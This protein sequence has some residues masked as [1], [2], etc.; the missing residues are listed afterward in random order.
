[1]SFAKAAYDAAE[2][3][4]VTV[5]VTLSA[6]PE[7]RVEIPITA[8]GGGG[9]EAGD[10][11]VAPASV[12][13][14][15]GDASKTF[16]LTATQDDVDDDGETVLL[17]FGA[18]PE[19][20]S[21]G[22]I[23]A[24]EV[25][26]VDDDTAAV[27]VSVSSLS[28]AEG[29]EGTYTVALGSEPTAAVTVTAA[30]A[31]G[32]GVT[33][34]PAALTFTASDWDS[35]QTVT[36]AAGHDD[37]AVD[38]AATV[39]HTAAG[40]GYDAVSASVEVTVADDENPAVRVS[41]G[42]AAY[43]VAEGGEVTV[44]VTLSAVP[45]RTVVIPITATGQN[46]AAAGDWSVAPASV[47]FA[48][49]DT[50]QAF[51]F[52]AADDDVDDDG[53][54]VLLGFGDL[55]ERVAPGDTATVAIVDDDTAAVAVSATALS[56]A[57]GGEGTYTVAL[58][59]EPTAAVTVTVAVTDPADAGVT[60]APDALTFTAGDWDSPQTVTVTAAQD[61]DAD[62]DTAT[63]THT[64]AGGDYDGISA[65][66]VTVTVADDEN[67]AVRVSFGAAAY[68]VA[69]GG[70][71]A[72]TVTLSADPE[73]TV[74][75]PITA[76]G[77]G[78]ATAADYSGVP[79][80]VTFDSGDTEQAF[81]FA[82]ADDA[83]D[84]DGES[85][86]LGFGD[87]LPTGVSAVAPTASTVAIVDDDDPEVT[88]SFSDAAYRVAES[89]DAATA[90][91]EDQAVVT[92]TLSA[93][94]ERT[95]E[96]LI[97]ADNRGG[98]TAADYSGAPASVT[99]NSGDTEQTFTFAAAGDD[100]D[101]DGETVLLGFGALPD[102]VGAGTTA[103]ATVSIVDDDTAA[104]AVSVSSLSVAEGGE[105]T[106]T[107]ALASEPTDA[108]TV[109]VNDP[110][111][112]DV[113]AA[114]D[115]LTFTA[116][117]WGSPQTVTVTA[118]QDPD[119]ADDT[120]T[121]THTVTGGDYAGISADPVEV[122]VA[123]D[124][125]PAVRVSFGAA[126][127][128]VAE[129]N[130]VT[131]TV[132]LSAV[133][134]RTVTI[135]ITA[136][137]QN[138]AAAGD[139]SVAPASVTFDSDDT[140][141]AFT[142]AAADDD[143]DDDGESVLLGFGDLPERVAP[144][145]TAT[146]AIVDDDTAAVAV[147]ATA[148]SVA[149]GGEGT[150]TVALAS[151]PTAAVTVTVAV[152][153]PADAGVTAAPDALTFTAGDWDSPQTVT[154][155]AA[156]DPD[157]DD[158]TATVT[159]TA[160]GG[161]YD[162][163]S[164]DPV[165]V[166]VADDEN[167]AVR[168]SFGAAAYS[169]AEGGG[170]AVTVTLSA[171]PERTV[172]IPITATGGGG[173]TAADYSGVPTIVT[174]DSG[175][176]E[177]AFTFA[178]AD[179]AVDDDG[180]SVLLGFG[181]P[182]P[183]GV[184]AV[185]PTASTVA[186]VDDDDPEVTVSFSDAAYRV[187]ESD[188]AAT[189]AREDQ[190]VVTVTLS[191]DP[192]RTVEI[193][194]TADNRG[195]A[196]AA[197]YSGAPASV[198]FNSGDTEQT[199]TFAAA[200]DDVDDDGE[201][202]LLGFG[203]LPDRV[204]AG[205]T[206]AATVSIVDDDTAA[207][208]VSVSSLSVAEGGEETYTVALASEPTD[209]VTVTVNDPANT[210]V[211]AAPDALTFT[212]GDWGSPQTVTVTAA[213]DPDA[214]DDTATV[215]H[216]VT[217]GDYAGI[218]ADPVEVTVA[219]DEN[220][221][222]RVSFGAAAYSVAEGNE[223][224]V[225]VTLSAVPERTVT[226]PITAT[227]Q[228]GAAAG[229]WSVA[230]ASV[231]FDSDDTEQAFTFAAADDDV[232]DDG[233]SVLLGFGDLPERVAP[234]DTATVAIVDDDTAAVAVSA[235]A[236]SVAEG[237]EGTYTVALAS[238]PTAAV[239]VTVAVT[240]P[241]DAGVT[242]AP[243][244][245]TFTAGDWDSPQTVTV[246]AAQDP[247]ADDDTATVTHTAAGGDYDG[248]SAD[249]V[250]VTVTDDEN[251][252]VR[253]SFGA[254][255]YSVAEGG[256]VAVTV[257]LSAD[258]ER[259]VEIP[260]TA[261]GGGGATAADYSGVPTIVT[262]DSGDTEQAF[263]FAAADDTVD[264]DGESVL[265]G[266]GDPLPTG[267]SA[268]APT[269]STV[270]I[271][272]D[273]DPEVTVSFS[274]A[275]YRV[276]ES[277]DAATA[278]R[279][280]QAVVTVTLSADP[281]RTV[282]ILITADN[283]GG[284]TAADYSGAP[285]SVTFNSGDTEQT[286]TVAA[287][288]DDV[289][290]DG[291]TV[292]LGFGALPERVGAGTTAAATVS[293]VDDDTAAVA[294]SVSSLSVAE[295]GE[296]TYT[297]AL[298]SEPTD[299]VTVTVNDPANTDVTAAPDALTFT[300][301]D[302]GSPQ[303][304][305]VTAAQDPDAAD[306]T[307]TVTHTVTGGDYAGISADP[308]EV[309]VADD[310]NP[311][312]RVSF[313][314]A[315]YSVAEGNEVTVTVTLSAVPE[316]TV[317]IPI[318][319][320]GQNGA[321]AGDYSGAPTSVTFDSDDTEQAF[322]FAAA[323]DDVDD[324]GESVLLGFGD[325][326]ERVAPGDT[327]TVAI[328]DDDTAAVAV[329][330]TALSVAEGGEGTYTV[331]LASEPTAAVTVTVAVTDPA[332]AGVTAAPDALTFTAG[333]WDSPQ[334]VTVTAAQDPDADDDT[335][336]VTHTAAGGDYDG[337]SADPVTVT[338]ADD[339][340]P[341]VRVS[342]GAAAYSVAEGGGVAVTVTLSAD[343]ERTVEIPITATG[344][345][346]A[347]AADYSG[348]PTI[349]TFDSGDT[350]QAFTF[351][352]A[353]DT[354]D[355]DGESVLLGFG[356]PLPTGVSAVAPTASTVAIVDDD[357]P[358]VTV[359][360]SD[361]AYRVAESDDAATAAREDQAVV[362]V[363]MS[364]DPERTVEILI[365]ADNRGGATAADYS[366]APASVTFNSGDTEQTFTVTA[367]G[368]DVDDDGETVLLG[369]GALPER[370]GAG[371]TA[372]ATVSIVDDDTAAVAVS[373]T[374]LSVA[375]G[376]EETYTVALASEPT[377]AVT[378]TVNDPA[379]TD[380][381]AA[382]DAL[383]FT[384]GDWG[385]PQTVTVTAAQDPDAADDTATVTHTVTG[386]DYAG[387]SADPVEVTVADDENPAVRVSF[388]A[389]AYSV[390]EGNEVTVTVTLSAVPERTVTIPITADNRGG[391]TA[392]D[393]SGAPTSVT[394]DSD[395]TEQAF[396]F[397]AADDDVDDD[398]ESVLLGFG[399][400]PERVAPGD[401]AT[402]AIVDD[403]TAAVA[404]SATALS[405]AEGGE[406]TYTVALASEPTAAVT[407]TVAVTD[408]ADAGVTAA[409]DALTF[410]A[411]DWD[412]PQTVT[413]T[414]AQDPDADDD[415]AT[416]THTAAGGDYDGISASVEVTVADDE[417]PAVRVSFGAATYSVAEGGGV[418]VTVTLSA[419][420]ERTVEI[421]IT[422]TGGGGATAADYSGA[423]TIVTF[424]SGDTEQAFTFA[425]ADDTVDDDGE[426]VLL[427]FG[428]PLPTG[429]SAVA[430]TAS[431]V[432]IVDD[433]DPEV[434]VSF[435]DAAYRV[436]ESDDAATAAREDQAVVT[437][438]LSADPER[439]VEILITADNRG[440]ATAA[441]YSGA[442]ASVTFN[443]GDTEQTFTVTA[444][445]DDV[446]DDG[447][448]V[449]L[450][451]GALPE[452]VGAGTT[453]AATVS[454]V[455]DDTAAVAVSATSLSVAEGGEETYT[456]ALA[457]EPT[458]AVTVTVNDPANTDVTAAPDALT[459]TA[460]DWGSPQTV[461]VTAAQDPDAADDTATVTHTVTGGDY[462]GIS[463]DPVEVT[464]ADDE[465]PAVR[466]SFGAAAYSVAEGNEVTVTVTLS[467]VP[468]R[469]VTIPITADNRG[470]ATAADYSG[471]PTSVTF[472]SDDTEQAFTFAAA[473]DDV[474]DDGE[475]VLLGFGDLPERVAPGDT[476]TVA[477]V[478]DDTAAVAVSAT[479]LSV[480]EGGEG[481]YTVALASEPTAA[482][483]VT[484]AVTDPADA[485]VTAAP[486]ALTFT[487]GDW[488]SPQT[489]TVTAAQDPD[490]D[491]D[492]ATVTHTA[493]GGDYDGISASV[494]VTVA[495]DE[496]PA[497][498]VSFG[499]AAYSVAEG[500]GVA[501]TVTLS[502]DPERTVEIPITAT[503][504][505]GATAADYSGAPTIVTFDSGDT[506]QAFT[507]AAADD[508]VDDDGESV[509][510]G[511]GDPL[512]TGVSA[513]AP[514]ASTVAI[515]DDDD[516]EV[517]VSFSDAAYRVAESDDA[518]TAA[519]E[520]Q[521]VVT[522]TL[523][524]DPERTVEI[525]ITA[526][527]RGGATAADYSGAPASVTFNSGDTEQTFTVTAAGDDVDDDGETVLLG[528]GALP[529]RVGAGTTAAATV[530]IVDDDTAAVAVSV[531]SLSVAEGGEETYTV[532]LASE[533]TAAVT[534]TAAVAGGG[535]VT[536][537]PAALTFTASDWD[538][539]QTVTVAAGHDDDAV[540][541]A[542]TV[543]H[544][545][546]GG[547]YDAVSASV[548]VTVADD[549]N[550]AVRVSFGAA[551]YSVA[552]GNE[553]TVTV[554]LSAVP[555]RTVTIPITAD[556]RGGA[557]AADYSGAPTSVT[558]DSDDTEQA[559]T[560]AAADDDVDDDGESVLLGFG[561]L[562]ERVAP[563][564]TATVAIVDDDTAA[565][566]VSATAL[567][568]AEGGEGTYTVALASEPTAA[569]T[570]TVA[571]T[572]PADAGV[573]AA[574]DALTFTAG[575]W[576]S[577]QTVTVT[578][579]QDPD[580]DDDTATVT[581]TAAGG[582][583][584]GI[585]ASVEVTV[586][587]DEN[588][589]VRVSFGAAA[590][591]VAEGGGVAVTVT[592]SADPERTVEIPITATGG[593]GATAADYSGVPTIVTFDSGDTEQAFTFAA[594]DDTVDDDGESVLLG[595]GDPLPTGV[596]AVAPTAS[597]VAI[598][599]DDDPEVTVSFS[600]AAYRVA[601]SDDAATA[602]R[603]DQAVVTVTLSADPERTVEI[604][605]TADNRGGATAADYSGAPASV[606]FNSGDTE[607][608]FTFAAAGDDVDD[609]GETVLLGFGALPDRVGAGTTAAATVS[610]VDDD[611]AAVAVS[612][613]SLSVAEG[614]EE[615]YTVALASEPTAAVTVTAAVAGGGG[616]TAAP[617]A[618]TFTASDWDSPQ[619]VTVAAGH[620]D[621]AVDGAATVT[622]TAA[623]G[624]YD[625]VS[626]SVEVTVADDENPAVRVSFG[627]A[628]YS[629]AEGGEVTVEVTLSAVP[630]RTVVIPI[631]A[632]GQ[633]G[634]AAGDWSVAPASVT[635]DSDDTEQAFTFAAADDDVDD[636]GESVLLGFGDLPE[637]VA[638]GD[639]ATVA[640]VDD[641]TAAVAVSATALSVAEGGEGT[642]TVALAS[643][644]TAAV[645]VTVAVTDPA[646]AG[647][648]AAPD[649]LTFTA[650]D[651]DS[652]QTVTVT[653]AQDP[654]ADDDTATVTHTAAG[655]DYDGISASVEVTVA[656]D[657]NPA[658][659]VSFGAAAYSVAEG[660]GV[661]VTVTLSADPERTVE[662]PITATGG[663]GATAAD[664]SGVPTIV[665]FDS[666][667]TEQAFTFAAA[668]DTVDDDGESVLLGFGD[669]LPTGVSAVAPT[670]STVAIVD[671]DDPEVTVSFSDAA[672]RVAESD[673]AATA[674]REDQAVVTV[675][676]SADPERT[677]EILITADNRGGATAADYSGAPA[678]VTFNSGDTEQTFTVAAAGDDVDDDGETVLLGFGALPERVGAG[679][680]AAATVS[681]VDDDTA[682]VAVSVSSLSVAEGGEETYTVALA[683]EPTDAVTVTVNDPANTD[684]TAAPDALTFTAGDWGSP[685]TVTVTA[686]QDPDAADDTA[687]VT[688][689][690]TGGDYAGISADPV[691]VTV[692]DDENPAVRV[693]FGAA[694]YSVAE[695]NEVTVTV[696][697][698]AVPERTVT[699]PITATGQNGAA[700]GDY[701][702]A[703]TSV[704]FD[705]DDT[706]QAFTF[707]AA[708]DDVDDD[709]ESVL[710]G[711]GDL[712]ERV[713][714]GDTATVAIVDDDTA[715]V[716]VS[717]TAL[718]VAEGGE[719]TYT[720]AL[721]SEPTAAVTVTVAVTDP[722]DAGVTAAP[723]ALTFTAG[724]WDSPQTV[725]VT[726]AQDPD[727]DDDT[728]TVTHTAAGGDYDGISA[729]P[730]TVTV[731]DDENPAVRVSFGA[732]AYS[733]AEGGGVAVTVTLSADP[734]RTVEIPITATGGGGATA[735]DYSGAPTIVTFDSGDTEQAFTFAAAD[736]TV[737]DDG[738]SVLLGF[739]DPLPTGVSA[740][741]PTASTVAIVDDDDPEVTVSFSDAAYRVAES[742]DAAT[743]AREDQAVVT[744]TMSADPER[745]VEILITA[746]NRGG[747]TAADYSG[748]PASVTFN[749]GDT[750]QTFTVTA[751]GDDVDDDG[752]TVL[753]GFG[754]L[755]ERV[756]A[757][758]TAAATVSIVDDDTA[759][760]AV[761]AT[762]LSVAEGGE[763]TYTV[764]LASE[765][766]DAVTVTVNDPANTD[767]TAAPDALT[768]T[769]GDWG[770]PQTVTVTAAQDPDAADDTATVTHTVTGGDYAG[771][772]ADP[773]EVTVADDENPAV[774]VS[775]GAAAYSVAEGNEVTVT[776]TLSAVPERTVTIPIT[777]DNRGGA[778]AADYSGAPTSVT[779]DSDDTEQAFTFAA[780]DDDVDDDGESVLLGFGDLPER[781][782]PGDTATVAIVDDDTAAVAVSATALSVAEGGEGTYTVAL[783]SEP[784]AAVTV[785]VAVTDPADAGVTAAPDALTFTAGDWDSPQ[786]VT[787]T[788]AQDPDA[789]DDT[790]TVTHTA[791][792]GDY[793][794]ISASVE[795]TVA[796]DEN[797][798]VRVSFGAATYSVA[799]GGGVAVTV[800]LS[801]DPE[802]TVEIPI[803]ATGGGGATAADYSG[804]PTI[805]TFDSG[806]TE[807]A[808]TFA[809][810]DDTV[811]DDG[812]S[813]LLGFG[814]P[815][816]TGVSAVAP[817]ASTVAIVDDDPAVLTV[818]PAVAE[819][820]G[821]DGG[822][823]VPLFV[824]VVEGEAR[825]AVESLAAL[826]VFE[827]TECEPGLLCPGRPLQR[828]E[829][830]VW[831]VRLL[832]GDEAPGAGP[833]GPGDGD[834]VWWLPYVE[835]LAELGVVMC[836]EG[837]DASCLDGSMTRG[838]AAGLLVLAF[839]LGADTDDAGF[840]DVEGSGYAAAIDAL[841]EAGITKG[842]QGGDAWKFCPQSR[843][844]R[845]HM[846]LFLYRISQLLAE[847][848]QD[849]S[850][851][852]GDGV[853]LFVDVVEGEARDAVESLA[854]LGVFE[855][856][857]CEPWLL[858]PGRPLQRWEAAVWL[859]RL[860]DG[861][862]VPG[863]GP[864]GP[865]DGDGVWWLPYVER[866]A[867]LGVVMC[868]E[869]TD[870]SC[871][872]G[873]MTRGEAAG[874]L[875]LAFGLGADA[876]DAG[877]VDVE[878][879]GHAA[880]IDALAEAGIT[881]GCQGG[882]AP[883]FCPQSP[884]SR[885]HMALFLYRISQH[886]VA[887]VAGP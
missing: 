370:V 399:D 111:N 830:A 277:D 859:V 471:A 412:S 237:G 869:G 384:A 126:A 351:A 178:A 852:S 480:A 62:D 77:G 248:I 461:T 642:Y 195:G 335:A 358:E 555:E 600:D 595:F 845:R 493:A 748:A 414:A 252:A 584:D 878:G 271:V 781:V 559:F 771:I 13:F 407:V 799:E 707:A 626:A 708:D 633:N 167:P 683:S 776:V 47:T 368:D 651:W 597:T 650:G 723:D 546:A 757:G 244:A 673:D 694:A 166:T 404:V 452:R 490:A 409:P 360:F 12:T 159:H 819:N 545:A 78:G 258:P 284:A 451:F 135:P 585:S 796:D 193:L 677:V 518:A 429:V 312:V 382:P 419:D 32:G 402:V 583:Y 722:A 711:F 596:S 180:E 433:D 238:E 777:A 834:G 712:P 516:P 535:G 291:E 821:A 849:R 680:T 660:G 500:G 246:T 140:E 94:P 199:F 270:A 133:P 64:A 558:F 688:H 450:G 59:S 90:A 95:V 125:N 802:R 530:S 788:A 338:V 216:T 728:A 100:V 84:D 635:F 822:D 539:P 713:A 667:D 145:D 405:V 299:A 107:V 66:P 108:V 222:V 856:T 879:S 436:A 862:E 814:D 242:A 332:D 128:S 875:V 165:T 113:T 459:F 415:T 602:A 142:F 661:A 560:F 464:V 265:L 866:L 882:D 760:V 681:I 356:D 612:V 224:T 483:T 263:T 622:H 881:K 726:A 721:A 678:S 348:V 387:I 413:V 717:A 783:A 11:S 807:Q 837:T 810:A 774:R 303:T 376:G 731:A 295:G 192:E 203:A 267:V 197:D 860:L 253:V 714:P 446:D 564:D 288:G 637:R 292:L 435:S 320:T 454:I 606:T 115:A 26:I 441:D 43:S 132:T 679:T 827:D 563:G 648:T 820:D 287:A 826:G 232:D 171:D 497:V 212:A 763:E 87:P 676:L 426:S 886:V 169:V 163:I 427:G 273:D 138:G 684:V 470:G 813:V 764:A 702:G 846:A 186:I 887:E 618:L 118:A 442:P 527:N 425:A 632:T 601:E 487:A 803:T 466:V 290:D 579:A 484:V 102:R 840:V 61:P 204:G 561:D 411:G 170:V 883:K 499:A 184:S 240:D 570:V 14:E 219:D 703:P 666:G 773:V 328:V 787:V 520:D 98:A 400:L 591:S 784:T 507:F 738:E 871:L 355:D 453:A 122:T 383:T 239:T 210:D 157:A 313:G 73:R 593:G 739:G 619:T 498:R 531:S 386:G 508:T 430:P 581:H 765:P 609:D 695:G 472:D 778:T 551:A 256:G 674:A 628:A 393:Y 861:D 444:A 92:V 74:E 354:V 99:F 496:N 381:T 710:L 772:S 759:A 572:D 767:V 259:T 537:A 106:Y 443:S 396:T 6:V 155:T 217:G 272:D 538:S 25:S 346:G 38:G 505:G 29:G 390:A 751:A 9:A 675:T 643:E 16:T 536:A 422:A 740:V 372:A 391:A 67:P 547:D 68:S 274:D 5:E 811:D 692:A 63:V 150:Y 359:S 668:D 567:S 311:A 685:Q 577:P 176:T 143:V 350:E 432:A 40:G 754:A 144:G 616:V 198:T 205:T 50:E 39:T 659:R 339:E 657:E 35:P 417:N 847:R 109:T 724:D 46:G 656:D 749:S 268:V 550:P 587:D 234:G 185:A 380:V 141:Q 139:W 223:V 394:F 605:I 720:V 37:D 421:P 279:E 867:E 308:V 877:L 621:D 562:P 870:A 190:A 218:S 478:D 592:L 201:T 2:G 557:T 177:Q 373:A 24:A 89:D 733:V 456:V 10:W 207:V 395:D 80:I 524:A 611:T 65:D 220:P 644:P 189:A 832:D 607:Q 172:E 378:V 158:D 716:A 800:T 257:T 876:D 809:A 843:L 231:T 44:E 457:S 797:P 750:E 60:A 317:T 608:T 306:D 213:Q 327:A 147:S 588:P 475:S 42:A 582:D 513:V 298:A 653:A 357:D 315:A 337:I 214:A 525:L 735:A 580:A 439:T 367:A 495:D 326:P 568:V 812:E 110:A 455:D 401:T 397:A 117:D 465:N 571:V 309:T 235:T 823:G 437:V 863:A 646:D 269:A 3:G 103:A 54:S 725:T 297:V 245:L 285:A 342:F 634:A 782:A 476:A 293:I 202:V 506:E 345:G 842:C 57:E 528:F 574:P 504:G 521:A 786:T 831:L 294:V 300:A 227:G 449:L 8:T 686:A 833:G 655:G 112:T 406:G 801:A 448:T 729:D 366:G 343:P 41:F 794:G 488:D 590:Y 434:T 71:V 623:G 492:T 857:E 645:T 282:E 791:A 522:V 164:A 662:I 755:P 221:A 121:V 770:S 693:S 669:P 727:A 275:A 76:T 362:T 874:L 329:S 614:G 848:N 116:G 589:A 136:T 420:P 149:E 261:T 196:T 81:T 700:A 638:P 793:D 93:D 49:G 639:T 334:T 769:A 86:L 636:D 734:E 233:E 868:S 665:T 226:I 835:R 347:T 718:S 762:S 377:D 228:N 509:L 792:G 22:T 52:A 119:A 620:D 816:P 775:F 70:G 501:V 742:D 828:W 286:F 554:T 181:D 541:G 549:E 705:S 599:D 123:D 458:D 124:E 462:A 469:T 91:R 790:A 552:E 151:E 715:A 752:E 864:G 51:T 249:P 741:A 28:V 627:A 17:G 566:A 815:L 805:V 853:P 310:E 428:D 191:A 548:E 473:D 323:D 179:D 630:E 325:L 168:V 278:A 392:A 689:T 841:A 697:L 53:E 578:A 785:T 129:G 330:A 276:A 624:G 440:G 353:D 586:T 416:V 598:V 418:A 314:A 780:A 389:A 206:A 182:L 55:P 319:A 36:V 699:I 544:T 69:E 385:S 131:V 410:T 423:P 795:V 331:A 709:G 88:V 160:A 79:T 486:D 463:A 732:A 519:R 85:V 20:V 510:L 445:G 779:F 105:E 798:A 130:E 543:T 114:P 701:S 747:A 324:D 336:T 215:T 855:D 302:W 460:G 489:V 468:E 241:A 58:A 97:T 647:V 174:F 829:A 569:V 884:L 477:I 289:D 154:V 753:L 502:A 447:E 340:N 120:A 691:E 243:D 704:T 687:T 485:G 280:D 671:D 398:G 225:T 21:A 844:S 307:A 344:G 296:E 34:A 352:A 818:F 187:A 880:A 553:V 137:G 194:I 482:V 134:E 209:A 127:Y 260:I 481:T 649:A 403:D 322:T 23:A 615:T 838:E 854:A 375:E 188:D 173:A 494:E 369:F 305:T 72:V 736:D 4:E 617:A 48:S 379:N 511:F 594:A 850:Q 743:A 250:T 318:T 148:L 523:S 631:T 304:V 756:G 45:E 208:A 236:L 789:D 247:D 706:E 745:T 625:A 534:V 696:T 532:A 211:T 641:D 766:T 371:T 56:V 251:P 27:A 262:F 670:A 761:S 19:R 491:D 865:G 576:D 768:F 664:Y 746:D 162:G 730:V 479:A 254:A 514:T 613:S 146:V 839:G 515:V 152:T 83:V 364:A 540:D 610:I 565:V 96:I 719:G 365:T 690:V 424:D 266:F 851:E 200:G 283:R 388:G 825:D 75:I 321:A 858:C 573:T 758:T 31:G 104:V 281:E 374:S 264:D 533:P 183:T 640:I 255:A 658:V 101:D 153:D 744:V 682:A 503:G 30:V 512:P 575:D 229:D 556:N 663:G 737:D 824:D 806:D 872:D 18:L 230:P 467:A 873:S 175:D 808:F 1:M 316:R 529:D 804:V 363:T 817:T 654:D 431:T 33:A 836:S 604:L 517:T 629:V 301:G 82:A 542:A 408:P 526:D 156:Q 333:D 438:T 341:A 652:P 161:D 672:Y 7:R 698:S 349:V 885:R 15:S 603:E 361:A 474:D